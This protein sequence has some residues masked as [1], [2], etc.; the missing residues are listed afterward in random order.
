MKISSYIK[1]YWY[2][3]TFA[4]VC[5]IIATGL[6]M[7]SP[8]ILKHIID[9]VIV[10]GK[11]N[12]LT[13]F[14]LIILGIGVG[15]AVFGY[16]KELLFDSVSSK[17][18]AD[19]R[20]KLFNHVQGLSLDYFDKNNTGELMSRL[21]D[22]VDKVWAGV[23]FIGML[24]VEIVIHISLALYGMFSLSPVLTI[25]PLVAMPIVAFF[26]IK[27][28]K[29]LDNIYEEIS[30][31]NAKL[32][33]VAQENL[34]GVR[35]VKA[36]AREKFE[37]SKFLSHNKRYYELNMRQ[38][39]V[40]IK[41]NPY[42]QFIT[43]LLPVTVIVAGGFLVIKDDLSLGSLGAFAEYANNIVWPM[44][45]LGWLFND[46]ASATA[47]TKR[48]NKIM[49]E[50]PTVVTREDAIPHENT[51]GDI[52]FNNVSFAVND[53]NILKDIS[54]HLEQGKTL[55]IMGATGSGKT[56]VINLLQRFYETTEGEI[57]LDG[58]NIKDLS[59]YDLRKSMAL[60]MQDVFLFSDTVNENV[61][62]GN[63]PLL[64]D[65][66]VIH[67]LDNAQATDFIERMDNQYETIIGERGV[68]L[69]GGQKQRIS[70][71]RALA[72]KTPILIMD[73]ST[74]ALDMETEHLIQKSLNDLSDTTKIIIAHRISAVRNADE[75]IFLEDGAI[76]E[77]GTHESLLEKKGLYYQT[78][79]AQYG[80][81]LEDA[82]LAV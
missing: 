36:F 42:F 81:Y 75:I 3:Y 31:E 79:M 73:D 5:M 41:Y 54:F 34:A 2:M 17:I 44:E 15:R 82:S 12:L 65:Q 7:L 40:L 6:D 1:K 47:S 55:G 26:S 21:K 66:E 71:A 43:R 48:I 13:T 64:D 8:Q 9:D 38:S 14:L 29:K 69:S 49:K 20:R 61:K 76:A 45:M 80:D 37:I 63:R 77:R 24:V 50:A 62:M 56:S 74:S 58:I 19:I 57:N 67:A 46:L 18:G 28:E 52:T 4:I 33:L 53:V 35:T 16:F 70:I 72:K 27:M 10:G 22:D 68:G 60:V 30:E 23:G 25:I 51:S 59:L 78:F 39:K 32:N 11:I